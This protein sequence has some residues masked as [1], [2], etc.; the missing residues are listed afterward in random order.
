VS[1]G[2]GDVDWR[3]PRNAIIERPENLSEVSILPDD[4]GM[5]GSIYGYIRYLGVCW[6]I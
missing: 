1:G 4:V 3:R 2:I 5:S 6:I